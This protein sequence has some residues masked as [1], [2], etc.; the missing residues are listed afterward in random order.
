MS[1][2]PILF[3]LA[4]M[5]FILLVGLACGIP[6][7]ADPTATPKPPTEEVV[8]QEPTKAIVEPSASGLTLLDNLTFIQDDTTLSTFIFLKNNETENTFVDVEYTVHAYDASGAQVDNDS[9][10]VGYIFPGQTIGLVNEIWLDDGITVDSIDVDWIIGSQE[11]YPGYEDPFETSKALYLDDNGWYYLTGVLTNKDIVTYSDLRVSAIGYDNAGKIVGGGYGYVDFIPSDDYVGMSVSSTFTS[12]PDRIEFYPAFTSW[13]SYFE[14]GDWWNNI[15]VIDYGFVQNDYEVGGGMLVKN[16]TDTLHEDSQF[17]VTVYDANGYVCAVDS[18]YIDLL[19]PGETLGVS[20]G[21][22]YPPESCLPD[23]VDVIVMP[24]DF[25]E[26][27]LS[28]NPLVV[29]DYKFGEDDYYPTVSVTLKNTLSQSVSDPLV[30]VLLFDE[31]GDIVGGGSGWPEDFEANGTLT[32]DVYV[33]YASNIPPVRI[34]VYPTIT[35]WSD[36]GQ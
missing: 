16:I 15:E 31:E 20:P 27:E 26:H 19:W 1:K 7:K 21:A 5:A 35:T 34:E 14:D 10:T 17:Y 4:F 12:A 8:T 32:M 3:L 22:I 11:V 25:S 28:A 2:K 30:F 24:G 13:T 36:I 6:K 9:T 29:V 23:K 33:T 18:G